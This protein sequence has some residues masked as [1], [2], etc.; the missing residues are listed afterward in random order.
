MVN[1]LLNHTINIGKNNIIR[2]TMQGKYQLQPG[3]G[4][5]KPISKLVFTKL[6]KEVYDYCFDDVNGPLNFSH[7]CCWV[8]CNGIVQY[9][10][11]EYQRHLF[12]NYHNYDRCVSL[13][14]RQQ[15]KCVFR[16]MQ[17]KVVNKKT[18]QVLEIS[19]EKFFEMIK[20]S[21]Q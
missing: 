8:N 15:G 10:P 14:G 12:W 18:G 11:H 21:N 5:K 13:V 6:Q 9:V 16:E 19:I 17:L 20:Q 4:P 1:I 3:N 7:T 2:I